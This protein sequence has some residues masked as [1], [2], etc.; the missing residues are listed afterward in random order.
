MILWFGD[1][2]PNRE[3]PSPLCQE[4]QQ[5]SSEVV[6]N[7]RC[8]ECGKMLNEEK[9]HGVITNCTGSVWHHFWLDETCVCAYHLRCWL[10]EVVGGEPSEKVRSRM[11]GEGSY[12]ITQRDPKELWTGTYQN[13]AA[14]EEDAVIG[15]GWKREK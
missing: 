4:N 6:E 11:T 5:I 7:K 14:E 15:R 9:D 1:P 2:W 10:T 13:D 3:N 12:H 8:V